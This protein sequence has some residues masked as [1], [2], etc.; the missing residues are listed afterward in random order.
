MKIAGIYITDEH[1]DVAI[2]KIE[3]SLPIDDNPPTQKVFISKRFEFLH[4][5]SQGEAHKTIKHAVEFL[6][7]QGKEISHICIGC[8]GPFK[9]LDWKVGATRPA[10]SDYSV[11]ENGSHRV[12]VGK[13]IRKEFV[14]A[15]KAQHA[16]PPQIKVKTDA[17][18][19]ALGTLYQKYTTKNGKWRHNGQ[20]RVVAFLKFSIGVGGGIA[21][22]NKN[23]G[24]QL[25]SE[26]G[27]IQVSRWQG[28]GNLVDRKEEAEI[29]GTCKFHENCLDGLACL[30]S[31]EK[32]WGKSFY[33]LRKKPEHKAWNREA[34][35]AAQLCI[36][37][38]CIAAPSNIVLGGRI[39][40]VDGMIEK[41]R[42]E[43]TKLLGNKGNGTFPRY[44]EAVA[45]EFITGYTR[46]K[47]DI[48]PGTMGALGL[49]HR[50]LLNTE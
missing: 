26:M 36:A 35:Y 3:K 45:E 21:Y 34:F 44:K 19:A 38:T 11:V 46:D 10:S 24:G 13:N 47:N 29:T 31:F 42:K 15:Y 41:V 48:G 5:D 16:K 22:G 49:A 28:D 18:V 39:M 30:N 37:V 50:M 32:R 2:A 23:W 7:E 14:E 9:S 12:L 25:H 40:R 33:D 8:F 17:E 1:I 6:L 27:Q 43:Y 4:N 20:D